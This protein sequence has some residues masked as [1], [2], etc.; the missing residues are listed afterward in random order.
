MWDDCDQSTIS[1]PHHSSPPKS[2]LLAVDEGWTELAT[3][4]AKAE[5]A[6]EATIQAECPEGQGQEE[7]YALDRADSERIEP[8]QMRQAEEEKA[9]GQEAQCRAEV[10]DHEGHPESGRPCPLATSAGTGASTCPD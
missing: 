8:E 3:S 7:A 5:Q 10:A 2:R 1:T 4:C 9:K 6:A